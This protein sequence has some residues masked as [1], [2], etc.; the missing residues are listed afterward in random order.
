VC[1][2]NFLVWLIGLVGW[3]RFN[4]DSNRAG[5][6]DETLHAPFWRHGARKCRCRGGMMG[7]EGEQGLE[8]VDGA[9]LRFM[10]RPL[11]GGAHFTQPLKAVQVW[12]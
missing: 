1:L 9:I 7:R 3:I 8:G 5:G 2:C 10:L 12:G 6:K 4:S 11:W